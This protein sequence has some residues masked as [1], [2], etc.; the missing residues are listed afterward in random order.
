MVFR[1]GRAPGRASSQF[2]GTAPAIAGKGLLHP[3][4]GYAFF[5][6]QLCEGK[7]DR[8]PVANH[9]SSDYRSCRPETER[10]HP[11]CGNRRKIHHG[12]DADEPADSF[13]PNFAGIIQPEPSLSEQNVRRPR[14]K[15]R[16]ESVFLT[17]PVRTGRYIEKK[18]R[19]TG[20]SPVS[21]NGRPWLG[22][23]GILLIN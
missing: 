9:F 20:Q 1:P 13:G 22:H 10:D 19:W 16:A 8:S 2:P 21:R 14:G 11:G 7:S 12:F 3:I 17:V 23:S 5:R 15:R 6:L 18:R 4:P